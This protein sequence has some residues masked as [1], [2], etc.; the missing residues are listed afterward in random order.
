MR[1]SLIVI[2]HEPLR[3][4]AQAMLLGAKV[5]EDKARLVAESLVEANLRGVD[6]HGVQLLNF[7]IDHILMG[8]VDVHAE[9][10]VVS[11]SGGAMVYSGDNGLGQVVAHA[12]CEHAI[13]LAKAHG[14]SLVTVREANHF[15]AAA[16]W[17]Q[18]IARGG[19]I[20][21]SMC[22]ATPLVPPWQGREPRFGTNPICM[23]LPGAADR[24]WL[25]DMATTT[26]AMGKIFKAHFSGQPEIPPGWAMDSQGVPTTRTEE[27]IKGMPMPLGG[28]KGS[29]L[30]F[31]VEILVAVLSGGAMSTEVGGIRI[32]SRP[33]RCGFA[34]FGVDVSR[35][36]PI[37][38]FQARMDRLIELVKNTPP[39]PGYHEVLVAGEPEWRNKEERLRNGI[40]LSKGVWEELIKTASKVNAVP[41]AVV[42]R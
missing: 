9:G 42:E 21:I 32:R 26:V 18:K 10:H 35:Y 12:A 17:S 20:G 39:A 19:L 2:S 38:E 28:Y 25:L 5:P 27:A 23:A 6:S 41:P 3:E 13:R 29:G 7:Y 4:F 37:E 30:A 8:C 22:N 14:V 11:E 33:M 40:P 36:L 1:E 16:F 15:G 31:M 34:F 24:S